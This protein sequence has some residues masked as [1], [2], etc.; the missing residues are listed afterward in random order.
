MSHHHAHDHHSG[1][2]PRNIW[3]EDMIWIEDTP[4]GGLVL[5]FGQFGRLLETSPGHLD[6]PPA[7]SAWIG[8]GV[9]PPRLVLEARHDGLAI[10]GADAAT[11]VQAEDL[12]VAVIH[13]DDLPGRKPMLYARWHPQGAAADPAPRLN[14]DM[15]PQGTGTVRLL[16]RGEPLAG[17]RVD[18]LDAGGE[19]AMLA[20]DGAGLLR[21]PELA[22]G[23][24]QLVCSH[25]E[26]LPAR[27]GG[28]SYGGTRHWSTLTFRRGG[29]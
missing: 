8:E 25:T 18:L 15:I 14:L 29:A 13:A 5:R 12:S 27:V 3:V 20:S 7:L 11:C 2:G 17:A 10:L 4:A 28:K 9:R 26:Q 24:H 6:A 16:F 1:E 19:A 22:E 23:L 21:L